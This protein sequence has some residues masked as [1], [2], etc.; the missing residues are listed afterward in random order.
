MNFGIVFQGPLE[1]RGFQCAPL[2]AAYGK[3]FRQME[4]PPRCCISAWKG[5]EVPA[6]L[7]A[8]GWP[9]ILNEPPLGYDLSNRRRQ[10]LSTLRGAEALL[11]TGPLEF[12]LK[13]RSDQSVPI[14]RLLTEIDALMSEPAASEKLVFPSASSVLPFYLTDFFFGARPEL[15]ISFLEANLRFGSV[16]MAGIPEVDFPMKYLFTCHRDKL[17]P[18]TDLECFLSTFD[19]PFMGI[20]REAAVWAACRER[21]FALTSPGI[22]KETLWRGVPL[23]EQYT[24]YAPEFGRFEAAEGDDLGNRTKPLRPMPRLLR[25]FVWMASLREYLFW[26]AGW[27]TPPR[28]FVLGFR[29]VYKIFKKAGLF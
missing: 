22:L 2:L 12:I 23:M 16:V 29:A 27:T 10:M 15:L 28:I 14:E 8:L 19:Y 5:G 1:S 7:T 13:I 26:K 3:R 17:A 25:A 18:L 11:R 6:E 20:G 9:V 4:K 24:I 21:H